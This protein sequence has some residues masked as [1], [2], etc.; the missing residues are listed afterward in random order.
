[1]ASNRN[2]GIG[3]PDPE[4]P[5]GH[6]KR[7]VNAED[8]KTS[9]SQEYAGKEIS[10]QAGQRWRDRFWER[11]LR[12]LGETPVSG[13]DILIR[14]RIAAPGHIHR[15]LHDHSSRRNH[16]RGIQQAIQCHH[17][18]RHPAASDRHSLHSSLLISGHEQSRRTAP[19][20]PLPGREELSVV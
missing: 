3:K 15:N 16:R 8:Q 2:L 17:G 14:R 19:K 1:M 11:L 18:C 13:K 4:A 7:P 5:V 12:G 10:F 6:K 9:F 20:V